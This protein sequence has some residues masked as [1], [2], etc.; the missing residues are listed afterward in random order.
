MTPKNLH[1]SCHYTCYQ[2]YIQQVTYSSTPVSIHSIR[3]TLIAL[4]LL[5][6]KD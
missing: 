1:D 4:Q 2:T 3:W 6:H 5:S